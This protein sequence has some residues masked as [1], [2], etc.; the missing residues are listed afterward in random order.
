[1]KSFALLLSAVFL[2]AT[3]L[4]LQAALLPDNGSVTVTLSGPGTITIGLSVDY[5]NPFSGPCLSGE[6]VIGEGASASMPI[7]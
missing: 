7:A 3:S 1:M 2:S 6:C 4:P 5:F